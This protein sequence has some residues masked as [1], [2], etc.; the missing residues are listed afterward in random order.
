MNYIYNNFILYYTYRLSKETFEDVQSCTIDWLELVKA[1]QKQ[2]CKWKCTFF[3]YA[4]MLEFLIISFD[5]FSIFPSGQNFIWK[6]LQQIATSETFDWDSLP[7]IYVTITVTFKWYLRWN[8]D[9]MYMYF[10][11]LLA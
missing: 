2:S 5:S 8:C 4:G 7:Y 6:L 9:W 10:Q 1:V 11:Q 3:C